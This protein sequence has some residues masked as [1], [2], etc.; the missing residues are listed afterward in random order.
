M[1]NNQPNLGA[2]RL[3]IFDGLKGL[4]ILIIIGYYFFEH[5][6]PGGFLA[7]NF[8]LFI[9]GFFNFRSFYTANEQGRKIKVLDYYK[10]RLERLFFP[11]L[12]MISLTV[13]FI[14]FFAR[15]FFFNIRNMAVS[16]LLFVN[17]YYQIWNNQSYFVQAANPS[18]FTHLWYVGIY[19]QLILL[20]PL[21]ILLTFSWHKKPAITTNIL[22]V[23]SVISAVLLGYLYQA[24]EDPTR[25]YY[26]VLTRAFAFTFGGALGMLYPVKLKPKPMRKKIKLT[27]N[28]I[29]L[30]AVV[31]SFFMIKFMYGTQPFAYRFGMT[32]FTLVSAVVVV[33]AIHPET[34][35]HKVFSLRP[36]TFLG[37]RSYSYYLWFYPVY[38]IMPSF[39]TMFNANIYVSFLIQFITIALLSE[40]TYRLFEKPIWSLPFGQD[41]NWKKSKHQLQYLRNHPQTL[42]SIKVTSGVYLFIV[43]MGIVGVIAAPEQQSETAQDLQVLIESNQKIAEETQQSET[44]TVKIVHN[45]EG[46]T[47]QELLYANGLDITFIGDSI[48]LASTT[49]IQQ[50][51]PKSVFDGQVGRQLYNSYGT[52]SQLEASGSLKSTVVTIL[53]SNGT[54]TPAQINDYIET[55]GTDKDHFFVTAHVDRSWADDVNKQIFAAA[56]RY[57]NVKVIDWNSFS[58]DHPEWF[59]ETDGVHPNEEGSLELAKFIAQEIYRQR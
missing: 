52:V 10:Q 45:I 24:N 39:L 4:S 40:L 32:L 9:A 46:L 49:Q 31:L 5:I 38:L 30:L 26:D 54:F 7:V 51:F 23:I 50:V 17:N 36:L 35:W 11:M 44:E 20:M 58:N 2:K 28:L 14:L 12:F 37:K 6:L 27:F 33:T 15:H 55:V 19:G 43:I 25:I 59:A 41:F 8:F 57:G 42:T 48:L 34:I 22:L 29:G 53:G 47:Q 16:S 21:L 3:D 56:Q 13:T 1:S 18:P